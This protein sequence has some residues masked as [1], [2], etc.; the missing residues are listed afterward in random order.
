MSPHIKSIVFLSI[1]LLAV[2]GWHFATVFGLFGNAP[3]TQGEF[4]TRI[5]VIFVGFFIISSIT[6][7]IVTNRTGLPPVP[8]ERENKLL[9]KTE[10]IGGTTLYLGLLL[11]LWLVFTPLAPMQVANAILAVVCVTELVK[12]IYGLVILN[13]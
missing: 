1:G 3:Q 11:V 7:A 6:A 9:L 8:D 4:F 13:R 12:I 10:R 2:F 5:G